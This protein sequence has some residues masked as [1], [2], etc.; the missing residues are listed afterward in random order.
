MT[1]AKI[2]F[3]GEVLVLSVD[4]SERIAMD[5][6]VVNTTSIFVVDLFHLSVMISVKLPEVESVPLASMVLC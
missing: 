1:V 4:G 5:S 6:F 2:T 3:F